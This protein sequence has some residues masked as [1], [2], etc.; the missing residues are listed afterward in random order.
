MNDQLHYTEPAAAQDVLTWCEVNVQYLEDNIRALRRHLDAPTSLA[1]AVKSNAYGH[2]L[3]IAARAF[4]KGGADWLCVH[5]IS[6]AKQLRDAGILCPI[7]CFGP[8][9][10]QDLELAAHLG[11]HLV[12]YQNSHLKRLSDLAL[13]QPE[14]IQGLKLHLKIETGN[15][16]QGLSLDQAL[17][18]T[19]VLK[20]SQY[21]S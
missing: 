6:E 18:F 7:Y 14:S 21:L 8:C 9:M 11:L 2:G 12:L 15:H 13:H 17:E 16:R 4:L 10:V 1:P 19:R 20:S 5:T 3:L